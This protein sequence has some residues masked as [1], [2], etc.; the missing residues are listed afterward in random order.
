MRVTLQGRGIKFGV[1]LWKIK[2]SGRRFSVWRLEMV[3]C[4][5]VPLLSFVS[6]PPNAFLGGGEGEVQGLIVG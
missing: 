1:G 6:G 2:C 4:K 3:K 5:K